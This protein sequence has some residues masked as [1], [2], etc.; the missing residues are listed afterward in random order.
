MSLVVVFGGAFNPPTIAH[1]RIARDVIRRFDVSKFLF[2][3]VGDQY[4]KAGLVAAK[5]RVRMLELVCD[6]LDLDAPEVACVS[7]VEVSSDRVMSTFETLTQ[8]QNEYP[9]CELAFVMGADNLSDLTEWHRYLELISNFRVI[10]LSRDGVDVRDQIAS[11]FEAYV[12][13]F[14]VMDGGEIAASV[15]SSRYR[16]ELECE[17]L[18]LRKVSDYVRANRLYGRG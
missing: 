10:V 13:R 18:V 17:E 3:P 15:S 12:S 2:V 16:A 7:S 8:L 9:G 1:Y 11:D 6:D 5:H 14:L 4:P